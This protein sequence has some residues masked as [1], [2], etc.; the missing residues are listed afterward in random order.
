MGE[1]ELARSD[2]S[3]DVR[4]WA[5]R[6]GAGSFRQRGSRGWGILFL[7]GT[8]G[9]HKS[10]SSEEKDRRTRGGETCLTG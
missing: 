3:G 2:S 5:R 6:G 10:S 4:G 8:A 9:A 7:E 1:G